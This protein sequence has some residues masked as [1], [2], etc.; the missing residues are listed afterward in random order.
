MEERESNLNDSGNDNNSRYS[1]NMDAPRDLFYNPMGQIYDKARHDKFIKDKTNEE[2]E[3]LN[4]AATNYDSLLKIAQQA[5]TLACWQVRNKRDNAPN[6]VVNRLTK[7]LN[8]AERAIAVERAQ[9]T[10]EIIKNRYGEIPDPSAEN[11]ITAEEIKEN[12]RHVA[13]AQAKIRYAR[14]QE[15]LMLRKSAAKIPTPCNNEKEFENLVVS[16]LTTMFIVFLGTIIIAL[17]FCRYDEEYYIFMFLITIISALMA[18]FIATNKT[19]HQI[20]RIRE[21]QASLAKQNIVSNKIKFSL[22]VSLMVF[23]KKIIKTVLIGVPAIILFLINLIESSSD[24][25][26][27]WEYSVLFIVAWFVSIYII[28]LLEKIKQDIQLQGPP[29]DR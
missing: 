26:R 10:Y 25:D 20:I 24:W 6:W 12:Y 18:I 4:T 14:T 3:A 5:I 1:L 19:I 29:L 11:A 28:K 16:I 8:D 21:K 17:S 22:F 7:H 27:D 13:V 2:L 15:S 23:F 9:M